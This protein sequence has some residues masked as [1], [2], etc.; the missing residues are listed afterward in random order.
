MRLFGS[1]KS[2]KRKFKRSDQ[3]EAAQVERTDPELTPPPLP[4]TTEPV[5]LVVGEDED[6]VIVESSIGQV[7]PIE[8]R[9]A[10]ETGGDVSVSVVN[11]SQ[12][13]SKSE[14]RGI[15]NQASADTYAKLRRGPLPNPDTLITSH[16]IH[17]KFAA[18]QGPAA[19]RIPAVIG[20]IGLMVT[21]MLPYFIYDDS[22]A[23]GDA[24]ISAFVFTMGLV[25]CFVDGRFSYDRDPLGFRARLRNLVTRH[26]NIFKLVW[27]RGLLYIMAGL[28]N[29]ALER[30]ITSISGGIMILIGIIA[31]IAGGRASRNLASLRSSLW[32][33]DFL[34][35]EFSRHDNNG[36]GL[37]PDQF[38]H[39]IWE[40]GLEFDDV[41]TLK[42][43]NTIDVD[44]KRRINFRQF[45]K[46]WSQ[47]K[48]EGEGYDDD[49]NSYRAMV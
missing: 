1:S 5:V 41:Y 33:G 24:I 6:L 15:N 49:P 35:N 39:F 44:R 28:L 13:A 32:D 42:A 12:Y 47:C 7:E 3:N 38:A 8:S 31:L 17:W 37:N 21:T 20:A 26:F 11:A 4:P 34:W 30:Y 45:Q 16:L 46:W 25:I 48:L 43:F 22:L 2:N 27:G 10:N 9:A 19:L 36:D 40:I 14:D 29:V 18:E 23:L